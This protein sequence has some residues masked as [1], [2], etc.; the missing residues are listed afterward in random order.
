MSGTV[1]V[2]CKVSGLIEP[3]LPLTGMKKRQTRTV[4]RSCENQNVMA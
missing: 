1:R 3:K 2:S 4:V